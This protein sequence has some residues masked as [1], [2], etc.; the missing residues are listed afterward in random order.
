[1]TV[2][3]HTA[4][5]IIFPASSIAK[6][7]Q[8]GTRK[9]VKAKGVW[10]T[11][12]DGATVLDGIAGLWCA[13]VGHGRPELANVA[14]DAIR[15]LDYFHTFNAHSNDGQEQLAQRLAHVTP[16]ELQH[17]FF[18][19]SGSDAND[20]LIKFAWLYHATKGQPERIK[21][22]SRQRA[23]HGTSISTAGLTGLTNFHANYPIPAPW[24]RHISYPHF[25]AQRQA[26][27]TEPQYV[28]RL[29]AELE[30]V[31]QH[32]DPSTIAAFIGEPIMGAGGV[33]PPPVGYWERVQQVC[34]SYG[35]LVIADEVVTGLGRSGA[36]FASEHYNIEPD[37]LTVAKGITSGIFPLSVACVSGEVYDV[38]RQSSEDL[39]GLAHGYTYSGHPVGVAIANGVLDII[40]AERLVS[41]AAKMGEYLHSSLRD[42]VGNHPRVGE[43][44]GRGLVAAVQL[45][46]SSKPTRIA[47][48][49]NKEAHAIAAAAYKAGVIVRPLPSISSLAVS[50]PLTI[51]PGQIDVLVDGL[52]SGLEA[53]LGTP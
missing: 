17:F 12:S 21:I 41:H 22:V 50:P 15:Q 31:I 33:L 28:D 10:V 27:E 1:M 37:L 16:G 43:V 26:G 11:D 23:Y 8:N 9:M 47:P 42:A 6:V 25:W 52:R 46:D 34:R 36:W 39:G 49:A 30:Q 19:C 38:L 2:P 14:S 35:I 44:R 40:E 4:S 45:V 51:T 18:G 53:E 32:E 20:T 24:V 3:S 5:P 13:N 29:V 7:E 48:P